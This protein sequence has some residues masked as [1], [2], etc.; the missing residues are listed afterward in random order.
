MTTIPYLPHGRRLVYVGRE[1]KYAEAARAM[2]VQSGCVKQRTGAVIVK[3]GKIVGRGNN[4]VTRVPTHCPRETMQT[5]YGYEVCSQY[6][7]QEGHAEIAALKDAGA[8]VSGA[9]LFLAGHHW[10]CRECWNAILAAGIRE[11]FIVI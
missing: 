3:R 2:A 4:S 7:G 5:G 8:D 10:V 11:V 9:D 1:H 6:C